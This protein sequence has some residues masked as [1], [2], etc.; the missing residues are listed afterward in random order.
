MRIQ[1]ILAAAVAASALFALAVALPAS[2][3]VGDI[4]TV[5]GTGTVGYGGD[6][7]LATL[8]QFE[9]FY[10]MSVDGAGNV[11]IAD[12]GNYMIRRI[13]HTTGIVTRVAGT[14]TGGNSPDGTV[15]TVADIGWVTDVAV[16]AA[17]DL[18][19]ADEQHNV[20]RR[21]DHATGLIST[22]AGTGAAGYSGDDG[23]ATI[24]ELNGPYG[25]SV[26]AAGD[27][28]IADSANNVIRRVD[29]ATGI[30]TTVAGTGAVGYSGDGAAATD[31]TFDWPMD[32]V[33]DA[34]GDL[35]INDYDN[36][37]IRK[38]DHAT[39]FVSAFAGT[40][41]IGYTGD[42]AAATD[43]TLGS[44]PGYLALDGAGNLY[45][46]DY[47]NYVVRMVDHATGFISTV[48]G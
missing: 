4:S 19:I 13:D 28:Y 24:A 15:A 45:I 6:D 9:S 31:A 27:L 1:R 44:E 21:V 17:G 14:G 35:Y 26:T 48:A 43:A 22:V 29:H 2:A 34:A 25:V 12:G 36:N 10:G 37:V 5:A 3:A 32:V 33:V 38:V 46:P 18:Y 7:G 20:I 23:L 41:A 39:G 47:S 30:I 16:N 40:G 8:A 42:G 11:Y